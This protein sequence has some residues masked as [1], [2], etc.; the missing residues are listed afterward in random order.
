MGLRVGRGF[1]VLTIFKFAVLFLV[2]A[3]PSLEADV[4]ILRAVGQFWGQFHFWCLVSPH[5]T[6][7][8]LDHVV[9]AKAWEREGSW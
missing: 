1:S 6:H 8:E 9:A 3:L 5:L 2:E 4:G 7:F